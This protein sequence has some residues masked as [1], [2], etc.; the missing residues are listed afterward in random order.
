MK[1]L[2]HLLILSSVGLAGTLF[3]GLDSGMT[4]PLSKNDNLHYNPSVYIQPSLFL[5][6]SEN[7]L[8]CA[9]Y[10]YVFARG[11]ELEKEMGEWGD[12]YGNYSSKLHFIRLGLCRDLG[13]VALNGGLG[14]WSYRTNRDLVG[15]WTAD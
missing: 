15:E 1:T 14:I 12:V 8:L 4:A 5:H 11:G 9:G 7:S 10:G 13:I 2:L 6:L 3:F